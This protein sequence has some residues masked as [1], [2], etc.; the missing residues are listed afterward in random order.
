[1]TATSVPTSRTLDRS[2][3]RE[4]NG[5]ALALTLAVVA[6]VGCL[7]GVGQLVAPVYVGG[8]VAVAVALAR[9]RPLVSCEFAMWLWLIGPQVRRAVDLATG[10]HEPSV[11]L[12]AAPLATLA[13]LP[14]V[15]RVRHVRPSWGVRPLLVAGV[16]VCVAFAVGALRAGPVPATVALLSWLVPVLFGL[17]VIAVTDDARELRAMVE[18]VMVWATLVIGSYGIIQFFLAPPWDTHWMS[19]VPLSSIGVAE[20]LRIRVFSTLNSPG[21]LGMFLPAALLLLTD[22]RHR[23]RTTAQVVGYITLALSLVRSAWFACLLGLLLVVLLGQRRARTTVAAVAAIVVGGALLFG[24][25]ILA[26]VGDRIAE[27]LEGTTDDSFAARVEL[28]EQMAPVLADQPTGYGLAASGNESQL[29]DVETPGLVSMD[30]GLLEFGLAF[31]PPLAIMVLGALIAGGSRLMR[32]GV[33]GDYIAAGTAAAALSVL[34]QMAFTNALTDVGGMTFYLLWALGLSE[35]R[36]GSRPPVDW[37]R[38]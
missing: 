8:A 16:A 31:G 2:R 25:P 15:R 14:Y 36:N 38:G 10:Y 28:H 35:V 32:V 30:S 1:M 7:V 23:L 18:R 33:R 29:A 20:P 4:L 3:L 17:Q 19:N 9:T 13:T 34:V 6:N 5:T 11:V 12:A 26:V 27:T 37:S 22:A 21:S 24:G